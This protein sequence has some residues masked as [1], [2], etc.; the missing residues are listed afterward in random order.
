[1]HPLCFCFFQMDVHPL[2]C[3]LRPWV[4]DVTA[5]GVNNTDIMV[6]V[7]VWCVCVVLEYS[8]FGKENHATLSLILGMR[9][10]TKRES[11]KHPLTKE[12]VPVL[13]IHFVT[14]LAQI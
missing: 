5:G 1:M 12:K 14:F 11:S 13:N 2:M 9:E 7:I 6:E 10:A 3:G 8:V 4:D